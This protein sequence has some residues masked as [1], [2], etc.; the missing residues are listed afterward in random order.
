MIAKLFQRK[1]VNILVDGVVNDN[2]SEFTVTHA[3]TFSPRMWG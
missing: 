2:I 1:Y 3:A